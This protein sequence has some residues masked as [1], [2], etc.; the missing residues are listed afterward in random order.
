MSPNSG[1]EDTISSARKSTNRFSG[2]QDPKL[3]PKSPR[4][5]DRSD[6]SFPRFNRQHQ[7]DRLDVEERVTPRSSRSASD[8]EDFNSLNMLSTMKKPLN[9]SLALN[10]SI[11]LTLLTLLI[12]LKSIT[13]I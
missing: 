8:K 4:S 9:D 12:K 6:N 1:D 3:S 10:K 5:S 13:N 7:L 11:N 2:H